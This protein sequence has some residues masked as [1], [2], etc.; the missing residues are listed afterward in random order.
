MKYSFLEENS[1][2]CYIL[3][4]HLTREMCTYTWNTM[5][6]A[7][8]SIHPSSA[9]YPVRCSGGGAYKDKQPFKLTFTLMG[10]LEWPINLQTPSL[11]IFGLWKE[12]TQAQ[13]NHAHDSPKFISRLTDHIH[14]H[15]SQVF[16][17]FSASIAERTF[18]NSWNV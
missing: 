8:P 3:S 18:Y 9:T 5:N 11:H 15:T 10:N 2:N 12:T 16:I 14:T 6:H 1:L 7:H 17:S 13:R 4:F